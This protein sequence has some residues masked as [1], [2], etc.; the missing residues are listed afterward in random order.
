MRNI[1]N[2]KILSKY[3]MITTFHKYYSVKEYEEFFKTFNN[4][5]YVCYTLG[6]REKDINQLKLMKKKKLLKKF[7]FICLDV[8]NGYL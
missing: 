8:P 2:G 3:K 6:I 5:D 4:P 1:P 7:S